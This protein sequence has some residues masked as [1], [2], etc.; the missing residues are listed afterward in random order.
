MHRH[1]H[2]NGVITLTFDSLAAWP[3]AAHVSTRHGGVSPAPWKSLNFSVLR[4][5]SP[6]NVAENRRR[7]ASA[8]Q[9]EPGWF[10]R[11]HQIHGTGIA[12]VGWE[13]AGSMLAAS[14]GL[15]TDQ[16]GLPLTIVCADCVPL[17]LYDPAHHALGVVHAGWRGTLNGAAT[18][19]LWT[20]QAAYASDPAQIQVCIGPSIGPLSYEVGPEVAAL[21]QLRLPHPAA[22][23]HYPNGPQA[24]PHLDLWQANLQLL[25]QAGVPA[26]QCEQSAIDTA[27]H[28]ADFFSHRAEEGR[29][30]LFSLVAWLQPAP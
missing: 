3:V 1:H 12:K 21:A 11:C 17:L 24:N 13:D 20:L 27:R 2:P 6:D 15:V 16:I 22:A 18:A 28:T 4:G 14:D 26:E 29:C 19:L 7:L 25:H 5:D 8:L 10:V 9:L 30:G 23:L